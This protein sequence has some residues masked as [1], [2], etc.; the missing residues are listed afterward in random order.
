MTAPRFDETKTKAASEPLWNYYH[1]KWV[2]S[3]WLGRDHSQEEERGG[4]EEMLSQQSRKENFNSG[5]PSLGKKQP[6]VEIL[7]KAYNSYF[8]P[9]P[10]IRHS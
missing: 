6:D 7:L 9:T 2:V 1:N 4:R 8:Q 5:F 10:T 3:G